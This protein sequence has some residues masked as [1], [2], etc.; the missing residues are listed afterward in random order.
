MDPNEA[1]AAMEQV[2]MQVALQVHTFNEMLDRMTEDELRA[3]GA[4]L[5]ACMQSKKV[6]PQI[7]GQITALLR[8]KHNSCQCGQDHAAQFDV[9]KAIEKITG[10]SVGKL[11][12]EIRCNCDG[13]WHGDEHVSG[14]PSMVE[15][16]CNCDASWSG[17][18]HAPNCPKA[19][20]E[21]IR[22]PDNPF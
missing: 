18:G 5:E 8:I 16:K 10:A 11:T 13:D 15:P 2:R 19:E 17:S 7:Y 14:C 4:V 9:D 20:P 12:T 6:A 1:R 21:P 3:I 22:Q